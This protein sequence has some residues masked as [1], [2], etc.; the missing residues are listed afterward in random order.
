MALPLVPAQL[1]LALQQTGGLKIFDSGRT[2]SFADY[3]ADFHFVGIA[4]LGAQIFWLIPIVLNEF[5][6]Y[7]P[8]PIVNCLLLIANY[9]N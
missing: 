4:K 9:L 2:Q 6:T 3:G 7:C 8:K 5:L 1:H